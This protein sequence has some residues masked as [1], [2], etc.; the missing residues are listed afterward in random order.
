M[1][2]YLS[3]KLIGSKPSV[4]LWF[5]TCLRGP[6]KKIASS[7][8]LKIT[9]EAFVLTMQEHLLVIDYCGEGL[10]VDI[11]DVIV[12]AMMT[13]GVSQNTF[14]RPHILFILH[15]SWQMKCSDQAS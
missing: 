10:S 4:L 5:Q 7:S 13:I 6:R 9:V 14:H 1:R 15:E 11:C 12:L 3:N 2:L 8:I